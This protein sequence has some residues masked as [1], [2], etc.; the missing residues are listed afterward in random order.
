MLG[1]EEGPKSPSTGLS[2]S[3]PCF[4]VFYLHGHVVGQVK[5]SSVHF[6]LGVWAGDAGAAAKEMINTF[7]TSTSH[8]FHLFGI[9]GKLLFTLRFISSLLCWSVKVKDVYLF[10]STSKTE[11][12]DLIQGGRNSRDWNCCEG[13]GSRQLSRS[14]MTDTESAWN[15]Q[16]LATIKSRNLLSIHK[17][18]MFDI[19]AGTDGNR[20]Y[21]I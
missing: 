7:L 17:T 8:L 4:C 14:N 18:C 16:K 13:W 11:W 3:T 9:I 19:S 15:V 12:K 1:Y 10:S 20:R 2:V 6:L 21:A 5:Q